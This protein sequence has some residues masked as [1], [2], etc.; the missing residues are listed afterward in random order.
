MNDDETD[1]CQ[2]KNVVLFSDNLL[3]YLRKK[4]KD[5]K[6]EKAKYIW[7][8]D[9][10]DLNIHYTRTQNEREMDW[11]KRSHGKLVFKEQK[12]RITLNW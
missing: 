6:K 7:D 5:I 12:R 10:D 3:Q 4:T 2:Y 1:T 11:S 9:L 8:G